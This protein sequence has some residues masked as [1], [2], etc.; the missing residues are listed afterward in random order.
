MPSRAVRT[1]PELRL[2]WLYRFQSWATLRNENVPPRIGQHRSEL[3]HARSLQWR[4]GTVGGTRADDRISVRDAQRGNRSPSRGSCARTRVSAVKGL[5]GVALR[6]CSSPTQRS[7]QLPGVALE[8]LFRKP[9]EIPPMQEPDF[10]GFPRRRLC[11]LKIL[12]FRTGGHLPLA[13]GVAPASLPSFGA[14][15]YPPPTS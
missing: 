13:K 12:G 10:R 5:H 6:M 3:R 8:R 14:C 2:C 15:L 7:A 1:L 4:G 9:S 11:V